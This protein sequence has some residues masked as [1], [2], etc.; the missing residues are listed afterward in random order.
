MIFADIIYP[1]IPVT[2]VLERF[3]NLVLGEPCDVSANPFFNDPY[4]HPIAPPFAVYHPV[5][6]SKF[7]SRANAVVSHR[8]S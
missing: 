6:Q 7:A 5:S 4:P 1:L 2:P 3:G 8:L